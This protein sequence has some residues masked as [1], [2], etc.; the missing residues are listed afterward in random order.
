M[1]L[2]TIWIEDGKNGNVK[3]ESDPSLTRLKM[4][5]EEW[6]N[7]TPAVSYAMI[8]VAAMMRRARELNE[9]GNGVIH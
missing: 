3:I 8:A 9:E 6:K 5:A 4:N 7:M 1:A 2:I